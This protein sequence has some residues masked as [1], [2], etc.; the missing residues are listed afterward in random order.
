M[1]L[2]YAPNGRGKTN[3]LRAVHAALTASPDALQALIE[4]PLR[5]L[6]I[7]FVGGGS[8]LI[9]RA[10]HLVG[11]FAASARLRA[12]EAPITIKMDPADFAGRLYRR[13]LDERE[14]YSGYSDVV[15]QLSTGAVFIGDDRLAAPVDEGRETARADV[16]GLSGHRRRIGS[17]SRLLETVERML[18]QSALV[19]LSRESEQTGTYGE[20]TR[21]T[22]QGSS[23]LTASEARLALEEQI[24][25]LLEKGTPLEQYQLLSM[26]QLRDINSQVAGVRANNRQLPTVHLILKPYLDSLSDQISSL[27][28]AYQLIDTYVKGVNR[29]LDRKE[30]EFTATRG[31][32]LLGR[33]SK[34]LHPESLS[35]GER[36]LL[37]LLSQAV[38]A[39]SENQ[40]VIVDE[41]E[42]SLGL[43]WQRD[44][45]SELLRCSH[46]GG[47]QFLI[48]SHS[49]Q[50]MGA[51]AREDI[52]QPSE[53]P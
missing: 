30:L 31:I 42:L 43:E 28:P 50:I 48:A 23:E 40:L 12:D 39:T 18:T 3:F 25:S 5:R 41:P 20:I 21:T 34:N 27:E 44:L 33:D 6:E 38:L 24:T 15:S 13:V 53:E 16:G 17:V 45:L 32:R 29:F 14:D 35:S 22:L 49:V 26:R 2:I 46:S 37:L 4:I 8:I 11:S 9:E 7:T 47:V 19:G 1:R 52:V 36:H 51:V 10:Q